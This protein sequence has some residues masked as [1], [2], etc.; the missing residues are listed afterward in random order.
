[1][2]KSVPDGDQGEAQ[3]KTEGAADLGNQGGEGV[4]QLLLLH[5][6][7]VRGGPELKEKMLAAPRQ[8]QFLTHLEIKI[9]ASTTH[10]L[11]RVEI[12]IW[13]KCF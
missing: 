8:E 7:L 3:E 13:E 9:R 12:L 5:E 11:A 10:V 4:D 1:M 6:G 2:V